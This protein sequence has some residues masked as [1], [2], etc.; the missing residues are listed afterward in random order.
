MRCCQALLLTNCCDIGSS[1]TAKLDCQ[2]LLQLQ[3]IRVVA[4]L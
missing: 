1:P 3:G 2:K 4:S